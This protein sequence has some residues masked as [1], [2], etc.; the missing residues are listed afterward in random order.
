MED[1]T[2][3][4]LVL[5]TLL[6]SFV[7]SIATGIITSTLLQEAP[8]EVTQTINRVVERTIEKVAAEDG[9]KNTPVTEVTTVVKEEDLILESIDRNVRSIVRVKA[10]GADGSEIVVGL[11]LV[12]SDDGTIVMDRRSYSGASSYKIQFYDKT[13]YS[14]SK[15]YDDQKSGLVFMKVG[16]P[17]S[18]KYIFYPA[19]QGFPANLKLGQTVI[20]VTGKENNSVLIGRISE[21][22]KSDSNEVLSI[23]TDIRSPKFLGASPLLNLSGEVVGLESFNNEEGANSSF[24]PISKVQGAYKTAV[25]ELSR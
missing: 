24:Y 8:V 10:I 21:I 16:K 2:K 1:L 25:L 7:T 11:G 14:T 12:I 17:Q 13:T 5:L 15:I 9:T 19:K 18:D 23:A 6:V 22:T 20:V 4:Q 3:H